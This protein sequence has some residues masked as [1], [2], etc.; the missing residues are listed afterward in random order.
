MEASRRYKEGVKGIHY[1]NA[2]FEN[3]SGQSKGNES[4]ED[5]P[6]A[7]QEDSEFL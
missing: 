5:E 1:I 6:T 7:F 2:I 3:I 4:Y